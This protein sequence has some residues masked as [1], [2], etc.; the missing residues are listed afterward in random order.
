MRSCVIAITF[1]NI[2][3]QLLG[4]GDILLGRFAPSLDHIF[5]QYR[6]DADLGI[7][8]Y[9]ID[10]QCLLEVLS[11]LLRMLL[12]DWAKIRS[13]AAHDAILSV[14]IQRPLLLD[15][16]ANCLYQ[17]EVKHPGEACCDIAL[18]LR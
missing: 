4:T 6:R 3:Q 14:E 9:S 10:R 2:E 15:A 11:G 1:K 7:D 13:P 8:R 17:L 16:A 18:R 5:G 12:G